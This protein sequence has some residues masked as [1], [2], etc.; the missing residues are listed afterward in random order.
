[1]VVDLAAR[2]GR[3]PLVEQPD[4]GADQPGLTLPALAEQDDVVPRDQGALEV[5][6]YGLAESDDA[7]ERILA[8]S[9]HGQQVFSY[10]RPDPAVFM[11]ARP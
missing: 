8:G 11:A 10:F 5:G 7:G 6:Q 9:H 2:D 4:Q 3:A 1:M